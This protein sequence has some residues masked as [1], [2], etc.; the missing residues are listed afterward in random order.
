[1]VKRAARLNRAIVAA[2]GLGAASSGIAQ[3]LMLEEVVVTAQKRAQ[4]LQD[5][6]IAVAAVSG[7]KINDIGMLS[8]EEVTLYT[9][10]V[11]INRGAGQANLFIRG[12]GSG[13]NSG[14]EQ[15][16]GM[17]IDGVYSGRGELAR[18]PL[19]MDLERI[20]V[21]KGPQGILFGKN[22]IAGAI[23][24][25]TAQPDHEF[26]ASIDA[27]YEPDHGE[28]VLTLV[29]NGGITDNLAGR[30]AVR[31]IGMDGWW[32]NEFLG[33]EGPDQDSN[34]YRGALKWTPTDL[35]DITAK[36]EHG[37]FD[38]QN[39]PQ[40]VY[41]SEQPLNFRG[42][43][44]FPVISD[45]DSGSID[46]PSGDDAKT[47]VFALTIN[48]DLSFATLTSITAYSAYD[49]FRTQDSDYSAQPGINRTL[50][51]EYEQV[52]QEIRFVSPGGERFD[53]IAGAYYQTAELDISRVNVGL[54]TGLLGPT[55]SFALLN[56]QEAQPNWFE[57]DSD[58]WAVFAQGTWNIADRWRA[59]LGIRY[60][61]EEKELVKGSIGDGL[62]ARAGATLPAAETIIFAS[63]ATRGLIS[64]IRSHQFPVTKREEDKFTWSANVQWD[65][66]EDAMLYASVSTGFKGGGFDESYSGAGPT[67]RT[68]NLFTG[69]PDGGIIETGIT[70][71]DLAYDEETVLAYELGAKMTLADGAATLNLAVFRMEYEDLQTSSLVGDVFTVGNAGEAISQGIEID[72]RWRLTEKFTLGASVAYLDATYDD[73]TGA[74][75][76]I[77]QQTD[78][79]NNPGC[80]R[81]DGSNIAAGETGGQDLTGESLTFAPEYS[82]NLNLEF[83]QPLSANL[84]LFA[85]LDVNYKDQFYSALDLDPDTVHDSQ[86]LVSMRLGFGSADGVWSLALVGKNLTDEEVMVWRNDVAATASGSYFGVPTRPRSIAVQARYSFF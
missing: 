23:N 65:A 36:Y 81:D 27:L 8:L 85:T 67:I 57:Q 78:P 77:P 24:I 17:Y 64:D 58:S 47:D 82:G 3:G 63:P 11:T 1:M 35:L 66:G 28:E 42:E 60:N 56:T 55:A 2:M 22:T 73:F 4:N 26:M 40:V 6:P 43:E 59:T 46:W 16:V 20:E 25:T 41:Q 31:H 9:P 51:E 44:V 14:F 21:L 83:L 32:D 45:R 49:V 62:A 72:G 12:V 38:R 34:Y 71:D 30:L 7:E 48:W 68:G 54:D 15:S 39:A 80:L 53:W 13:S 37:D 69:E 18:V 5:V 33:T 74:T 19:T 86:T 84:G 79:T 29:L 70:G 61:E 10:N 76:T 50:D 52:S 75:C